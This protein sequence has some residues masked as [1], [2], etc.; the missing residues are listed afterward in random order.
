MGRIERFCPKSLEFVNQLVNFAKE[1][2]KRNSRGRSPSMVTTSRSS[3]GRSVSRPSK[4]YTR[5]SST[6]WRWMSYRRPT[7][8]PFRAYPACLRYGWKTRET[9]TGSSAVWMK[10]TLWYSS[11]A[12]RRRE[13]SCE[14]DNFVRGHPKKTQR[15]EI[16]TATRIMKEYLSN[17]KKAEDH[18]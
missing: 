6:S 15:K 7:W 10:A 17:K 4:R 2:W 14:I 3:S 18:G 1:I 11:T 16:E 8:S 9:S 12:S 5:Y 13:S